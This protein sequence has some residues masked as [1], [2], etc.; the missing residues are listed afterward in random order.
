MSECEV[1]NCGRAQQR[2]ALA[3][4]VTGQFWGFRTSEAPKG[5]D[6][7]AGRAL[8]ETGVFTSPR[9]DVYVTAA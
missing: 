3:G 9:R 5:V 6:G 8:T 7:A 2:L 1:H 4:G